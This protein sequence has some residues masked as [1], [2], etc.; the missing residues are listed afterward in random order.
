MIYKMMITQ[1]NVLMDLLIR[2]PGHMKNSVNFC[3]VLEVGISC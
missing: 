2:D 3:Y 1:N